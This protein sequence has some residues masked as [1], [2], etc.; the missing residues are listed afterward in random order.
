MKKL[1]KIN[2]RIN[3]EWNSHE[4]IVE[5]YEE[6]ENRADKTREIDGFE[7]LTYQLVAFGDKEIEA[8]TMNKLTHCAIELDDAKLLVSSLLP[9]GDNVADYMKTLNWAS[10]K[11]LGEYNS[12][13]RD[14]TFAEWIDIVREKQGELYIEWYTNNYYAGLWDEYSTIYWEKRNDNVINNARMAYLDSWSND[15]GGA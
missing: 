11:L 14:E 3:G 2:S 7:C 12:T 5:S 10:Y 4:V 6:L 1:Y 15:A 8:R 13:E 9:A